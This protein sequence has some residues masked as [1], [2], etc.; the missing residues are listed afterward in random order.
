MKKKTKAQ[1]MRD[2]KQV[3]VVCVGWQYIFLLSAGRSNPCTKGER[4]ELP[5]SKTHNS[6]ALSGTEIYLMI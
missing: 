1:A 4:Y 2:M 5:P 6:Y 3:S